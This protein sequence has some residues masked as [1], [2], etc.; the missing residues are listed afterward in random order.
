MTRKRSYV[1]LIVAAELL[2]G[3]L[4]VATNVAT[5]QLPAAWQPYLWIAWPLV[6]V[7]VLAGLTVGISL[8]RAEA[9][10]VG[11]AEA[12]SG[13]KWSPP[14]APAEVA[15]FQLPP[16]ISDFTGRQD[17]VKELRRFLK[18]QDHQ[19]RTAVPIVVI[20]GKPGVGKTALAVHVAHGLREHF[21]DAQLYVNLRGAEAERL[22]SS[23]VLGELLRALGADTARI[24]EGLEERSLLYRAWLDG[25]RALVVLDNAAGE[26]QVRPLLPSSP[27][28]AVLITS[29]SR[30]TGLG[31]RIEQ[32]S[33]LEPNQALELLSKLVGA[34]RLAAEST[35]AAAI[36]ELCGRLP[37]AVRIAGAKLAAR[38]HWRLA[39]LADRLKDERLLLEELQVGDLEVRA[40]L[41]LS[42]NDR[43]AAERRAF[44]LLGLIKA[45]DFPAWVVAV[46]LDEDLIRA[47]ELV[48]RLVEAQ[49]LE[50]AQQ[51]ALGQIRYRFHDLLRLF[52]RECLQ[53]E[54]SATAQEAALGRV[55]GAYLDLAER[56]DDSLALVGLR[57]VGNRWSHSWAGT[58]VRPETVLGEPMRWFV[59]ERI[60]VLA[61][62]ERAFE[63]ELWEPVWRLAGALFPFLELR[64]DWDDWR[65]THDLAV[66]AARR[67]GD[68]DAEATALH[69]LGRSWAEQSRFD[70]AMPYFNQSLDIFQVTGN[71]SGQA[72]ALRS[73]GTVHREQGRW[74]GNEELSDKAIAYLSQSLEAFRHLH[75]SLGEAHTL[76]SIGLA[77]QYRGDLDQAA[78][79]LR[80]SLD[81]F[82]RIGNHFGG[83]YSWVHLGRI[84]RQQGRLD[85]ALGCFEQCLPI[86]RE[87]DDRRWE[88]H[89]LQGIAEVYQDRG[90]ADDAIVYLRQGVEILHE[91]G[92]RFWE[93]KMLI[94]LGD[95][96]QSIGAKT[97]ARDAWQKALAILRDIASPEV[98]SVEARLS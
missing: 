37:L 19:P 81:V 88:A 91:A 25:K 44:R 53:N 79:Y 22:D 13:T 68:R 43:T 67:I 51:D 10:S 54:E 32:L 59:T 95:V 6:G 69:N 12:T 92:D 34:E 29:R 60:S 93:A 84:Y 64:A 97:A 26:A 48:E 55:V 98:A 28:C 45:P 16:D 3:L 66:S 73:I 94:G 5:T 83:A 78:T 70:Q 76:R 38:D 27:S 61:L 47:E 58:S 35:T 71:E 20:A 7:L 9:R 36:V 85:E 1:V 33:A 86:F 24:P 4:A 41:G 49:L 77:Y 57:N 72:Y 39:K 65:R 80:H 74:N 14:G 31:A 23:S 2:A 15:L 63:A 21:A 52:A 11:R 30:L 17:L 90:Q 40:S 50:V 87:A 56:A 8:Y 82:Q 75:D 18:R 89:A 62:I 46:L 96:L 42:Y